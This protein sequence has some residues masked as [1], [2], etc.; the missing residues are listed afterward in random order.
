MAPLL[1][2]LPRRPSAPSRPALGV[3]VLEQVWL[4]QGQSQFQALQSHLE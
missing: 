1:R 4:R 2:A 3:L